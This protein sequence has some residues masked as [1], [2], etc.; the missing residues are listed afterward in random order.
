MTGILD[1]EVVEALNPESK[2]VESEFQNRS[3]HQRWS[4]TFTLL[5]S[6]TDTRK[7]YDRNNET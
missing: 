7:H 5:Q 3:R 1:P 4:Y 2:R 6:E